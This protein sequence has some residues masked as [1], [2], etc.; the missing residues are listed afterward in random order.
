[1]DIQTWTE[2]TGDIFR[3]MWMSVANYLPLLIGALVILLF[4]L[5]LAAI[6]RY[7]VEQIVRTLRIDALLKTIGGDVYVERAGYQMNS[8]KF[9]GLLFYWFILIIFISAATD[10]LRIWYVSSFLQELVSYVPHIIAAIII[11]LA[12]V[13]VANFLRSLVR[14]SVMSARLHASKFLGTLAWWSVVIF[15]LLS[16]LLQL[17]IASDLIRFSIMGV[18]AMIALAGGLAFG[19]GGKE[20]AAH[21][22]EKLRHA[23]EGE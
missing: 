2:T 17:G 19:L 1:M 11:M 6:V 3:N 23:T 20:Y 5:I 22:L 7:L 12:A 4:G 10:T 18:I 13:L 14:G 9:F 21:L 16:A 8:G 15:G